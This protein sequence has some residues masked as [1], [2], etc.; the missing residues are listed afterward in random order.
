MNGR[1]RPTPQQGGPETKQGY[2]STLALY[3]RAGWRGVLAI[4]PR[5]KWSP[6]VEGYTGRGGRWPTADELDAWAA[7]RADWNLVLRVPHGTIGIDVDAYGDKRGGET[8]AKL[9]AKLGPLPDTWRSTSRP[10]DPVSGIRWFKAPADREYHGVVQV[11]GTKD[12]EVVQFHHRYGVVWPSVHPDGRTYVWFTPAGEL[13]EGKVPELA[14]LPEL[15]APWAEYLDAG[16]VMDGQAKAVREIDLGEAAGWRTDGEL[17]R[18]VETALA[19]FNGTSRHDSMLQ[20][21]VGLLRLGEQG[22]RG[23]GAALDTLEAVFVDAVTADGS[24]TPGVA[25]YEWQSALSG[26]P[27]EIDGRTPPDRRGCCGARPDVLTMLPETFWE[28]RPSLAHIRQAAHSR[29]RSG[30]LVLCAVLARLSA[31]VSHQLRMQTGLGE[32]S[33]NLF[34]AAIGPSGRGKSAAVA[35]GRELVPAPPHLQDPYLF[36][37]GLPIGSGEGLAEAYM[38]YETRETGETTKSGEPKIKTV[39]TQ[40]RHNVFVYVDEGQALT[41]MI[42]RAGATIGPVLRSAAMGELL[43]QANAREETTRVLPAGSY[44]LGM[45]IGFQRNTV[46][47]ILADATAGTPQRILWCSA[48]DPGVPDEPPE[49]PGPLRVDLESEHFAGPRGGI[50]S[51]APEIRAELWRANLAR[52]RGEIEE[53]DDLDSHAN[54]MRC[55]VA[56]LL[57]V[58]D[59]RLEVADDDWQLARVLWETSCAVRGELVAYGQ[60]EAAKQAEARADAYVAR[61]V[62]AEVARG[63]AGRTLVRVAAHLARKIHEKGAMKRKQARDNILASRDKPLFADALQH[64]VQAGWLVTDDDSKQIGP[65][66]STPPESGP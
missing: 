34:V 40:V 59:G 29:G 27:K 12:I 13:A 6:S 49:H 41:A 55:K 20:L 38:G 48:T 51:F 18:A 2:G 54:L 60:E 58:L 11:D 35:I 50:I 57:A 45:V 52:V 42:G 44:A 56:A 39:R 43:G 14:A 19:K 37:D 7:E 24:R 10:D 28:S 16:S 4:E 46:Q 33:L 31:M 9:E 3:L 1:S 26:A 36:R 23:V 65:G 53:D 66:G 5:T 47:P 63:E 17:C 61:E 25:A 62:R 30:D 22:H 15:P 21:Q 8:L 64:A 32:A